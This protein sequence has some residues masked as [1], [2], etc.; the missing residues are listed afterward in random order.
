M[1]SYQEEAFFMA[2]QKELLRQIIK[3]N[4]LKSVGDVYSLLKDSFKDLLQELLEAE[5]D[6]SLGHYGI[7]LSAEKVSKITDRILPEIKEWQ[8]RTLESIYPFIFMDVIHYKMRED[9]RI[10]NRVA[11]VV[12]G[13]TL[14]GNKDILSIT[15]G[16]NESSK[17]WLEM[18]N[19][20]K[21]YKC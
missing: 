5:L 17:F 3:E 2:I 12:L 19:H 18:L 8:S 4:D 14:E 6:V 9:R 7:D 1:K 11:Y 15:I 21:N 20:L 16:A 10:L 13:V